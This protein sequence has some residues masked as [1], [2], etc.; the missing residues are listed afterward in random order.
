MKTLIL[1]SALVTTG[2]PSQAQ[3]TSEASCAVHVQ[4]AVRYVNLLGDAHLKFFVPAATDTNRAGEYTYEW[5]FT[6]H[7]LSQ[8]IS[9]DKEPVIQALC[10]NPV[11]QVRVRVYASAACYK[12]FSVVYPEKGVTGTKGQL[13]IAPLPFSATDETPVLPAIKSE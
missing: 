6:W 7:N 8:S 4:D 11:K 2:L 13:K 3:N 1:L 12:E 9:T 10:N 5:I